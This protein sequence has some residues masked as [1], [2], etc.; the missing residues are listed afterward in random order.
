MYTVCGFD[1]LVPAT[2]TSQKLTAIADEH[3]KVSGD[4][5]I[6]PELSK[7]LGVFAVGLDIQ[8]V[9]LASPSLRRFALF[10]V[11]PYEIT[12][13]PTFPPD[14]I[15]KGESYLD[16]IEDEFLTA[17]AGNANAAAQHESVI[18]FLSDGDVAPLTGR[19]HTIKATATD[20]AGATYAW[21]ASPLT[22]AQELPVGDYRLVGARCVHANALAFRF[23]FI[24]G[25]WR[26]GGV[27]V[28]TQSAKDPN[29]HRYGQIGLWGTFAHNRVPSIE[30]FG[31][32]TGAS[33]VVY[34]DLIAV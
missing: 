8:N 4:N 7:L 1:E 22:L 30:I 29:Y 10:D 24:G 15:V 12:A 31:D 27:C 16:L 32:G 33:V 14:P 11:A 3:I 26:P 20:A 18:V 13:L 28:G 17:Y 19:I 5:V 6:I 23:I 34:L 9:Q 2:T 21:Q 25:I